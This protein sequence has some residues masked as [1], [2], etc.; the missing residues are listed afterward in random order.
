[1]LFFFAFYILLF[2]I[3]AIGKLQVE[4]PEVLRREFAWHFHI[5]AI[6]VFQIFI[7]LGNTHESMAF[8]GDRCRLSI[9]LTRQNSAVRCVVMIGNER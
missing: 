2:Q 1:M 7:G 9:N 6:A 5:V 3:R 8:K 4:K